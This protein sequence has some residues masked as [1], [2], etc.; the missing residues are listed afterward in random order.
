V[1]PPSGVEIPSGTVSTVSEVTT[2]L[3]ETLRRLP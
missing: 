3:I 1:V 2:L